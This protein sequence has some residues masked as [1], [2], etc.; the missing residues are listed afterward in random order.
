MAMCGWWTLSGA[1]LL[2]GCGGIVERSSGGTGDGAP[3]APSEQP[4]DD[5]GAPGIDPRSDTELGECVLGYLETFS[6]PCAW[7]ADDRCYDARQMACNCVCPR[8]RDSQ[9]TSGFDGGP[10]GHVW[11]DCR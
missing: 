1:V 11:V 6:K 8:D 9:C 4:G 2:V 5:S 3:Q 10:D 7:V